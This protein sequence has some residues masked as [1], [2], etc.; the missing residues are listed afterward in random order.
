MYSLESLLCISTSFWVLVEL[1]FS[2]VFNLFGSFQTFSSDFT[3]EI[4]KKCLKK[5]KKIFNRD[6]QKYHVATLSQI[7]CVHIVFE[8]NFA[9]PL[10]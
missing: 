6:Y 4:N 10:F 8:R 5:N 3:A 2:A 1:L 7:M 9:F